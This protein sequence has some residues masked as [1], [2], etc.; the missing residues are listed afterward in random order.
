VLAIVAMVIFVIGAVVGWVDKSISLPHLLV[1]MFVGL[2][3]LACH[4]IARVYNNAG[5]W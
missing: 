4:L 2:A 1:I 3:F 5:R